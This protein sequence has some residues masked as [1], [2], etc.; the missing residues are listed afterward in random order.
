[1]DEVAQFALDNGGV[2]F[3]EVADDAPGVQRASR[4][5]RGF[6]EARQKLEDALAT[7][8]PT[9]ERVLAAVRDLAPDQKEIE[10]GIKLNVEAG[11]VIAKTAAEAHF[12]VKLTWTGTADRQDPANVPAG[13]VASV[14]ATSGV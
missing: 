8:R 2:A 3:I 14:E 7:V 13:A 11:A 1:M 10:F 6:V 9:A 5:E 12:T 4:G